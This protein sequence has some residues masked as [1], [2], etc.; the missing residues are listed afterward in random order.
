MPSDKSS[1]KHQPTSYTVGKARDNITL[2]ASG[3]WKVRVDVSTVVADKKHAQAT[4]PDLDTALAKQAEWQ[5]QV[6]AGVMP[7]ELM[8]PDSA[9]G[10]GRYARLDRTPARR[11]L[12]E[13]QIASHP[14]M[15]TGMR[16]RARR[17]TASYVPAAGILTFHHAANEYERAARRAPSDIEA[18]DYVCEDAGDTP[19]REMATLAWAQ[20][21]VR[22][23]QSQERRLSPGT[24][25]KRIEA[26]ARVLDHHISARINSATA[27]LF[28]TNPLRMLTRGY[29][30]YPHDHPAPKFDVTRNR[31]LTDD[32][33]ARIEAVFRGHKPADRERALFPDGSK[34]TQI[35]V[36]FNLLVCAGLRLRE[37]YSLE[38]G[39]LDKQKP[40][41][42]VKQSKDAKKKKNPRPV[43]LY[44]HLYR[45]LLDLCEGR[46]ERGL[47][48]G[49]W[50]GVQNRD[51][52]SGEVSGRL[53]TI[54]EHAQVEDLTVHDLRHEAACRMVLMR[55]PD[56]QFTFP[57]SVIIK[58]FGWTSAD[59]LQ[60]YLS[61]RGDDVAELMMAAF[62]QSSNTQHLSQ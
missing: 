58:T 28:E 23:M 2:T 24:I 7:P 18:I 62:P 42:R 38:V 12:G 16:S 45:Q 22:K 50:D 20:K 44:P 57:D 56:N 36:L 31:R 10:R 60:R 14:T 59:M 1:D 52:V 37:A 61:L 33:L 4:L 48:F 40:W 39:A 53:R 17:K 54:F 8:V 26:A 34:V 51:E 6:A 29:A 55:N 32:E 9:P 25:R 19:L 43:P 49:F 3:R 21:Y 13:L 47:I 35:E 11:S 5:S 46:D 27:P 41:I 15:D 30:E